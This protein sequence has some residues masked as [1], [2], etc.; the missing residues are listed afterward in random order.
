MS[1]YFTNLQKPLT[2][3]MEYVE[4][5]IHNNNPYWKA[6]SS[7]EAKAVHVGDTLSEAVGGVVEGIEYHWKWRNTMGAS[8]RTAA[9]WNTLRQ[10]RVFNLIRKEEDDDWYC[11]GW[12]GA[13]KTIDL[14]YCLDSMVEELEPLSYEFRT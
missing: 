4:K 14:T 12:N 10:D 1:G 9:Y 2:I 7:W 3:T 5:S 13:I 8:P 6:W 11:W